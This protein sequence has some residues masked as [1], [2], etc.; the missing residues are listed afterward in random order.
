MTLVLSVLV[1][2]GLRPHYDGVTTYG[3]NT[4]D[5]RSTMFVSG[6]GVAG[7][8]SADLLYSNRLIG[9]VLSRLYSV[10]PSVPWYGLYLTGCHVLAH[11]AICLGWCRVA[12]DNRTRFA[13]VAFS[14]GMGSYFWVALQFTTTAAMMALAGVSLIAA[15]VYGEHAVDSETEKSSSHPDFWWAIAGWLFLLMSGLIRWQALLMTV[16]CAPVLLVP[17]ILRWRSIATARNAVLPALAV[18]TMV[19]LQYWSQRSGES[20]AEWSEFRKLKQPLAKLINNRSA[21]S[22]ILLEKDQQLSEKTQQALGSVGWSHNDARLFFRWLYFDKSVYSPELISR[23]NR[24]L[25]PPFPSPR[26]WLVTIQ[27]MGK[28]FVTDKLIL[29]L[30]LLSGVVAASGSNRVRVGAIV[31]WMGSVLLTTA[32][33]LL[34][35]LPPHVL[36]SIVSGAFFGSVSISVCGGRS[37]PL[38][39]GDPPPTETPTGNLSRSKGRSIPSTLLVIAASVL[40]VFLVKSHYDQ[41]QRGLVIRE[42]F[43]NAMSKLDRGPDHIYVINLQFPFH[44]VSPFDTMSDWKDLRFHYTDGDTRSPRYE[45]FLRQNGINDL[46]DAL[47]TDPRVRLICHKSRPPLVAEFLQQHHG[48][49]VEWTVERKL[50]YIT[51]FRIVEKADEA[52]SDR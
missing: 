39:T 28:L 40:A 24:Q 12:N 16:V 29:L 13:I 17:V 9:V 10:Q 2:F 23:L 30:L 14:L 5:V 45:E 31:A 21:G 35:K 1:W 26:D 44:R 51:V 3:G 47:Y 46:T 4:D 37:E 15:A 20:A 49:E 22:R 11:F 50:P 34:L 48:V 27:G 19:G 8:P 42:R 38:V 32:V 18:A 36:Y 33:Y 52:D 41:S 43:L 7:G 25:R 6:V